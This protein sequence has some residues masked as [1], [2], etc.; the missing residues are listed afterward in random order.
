[1]SR[2]LD[3]YEKGM[4]SPI[5]P[6]LEFTARQ[7]QEPFR[8]LQ[9]GTHIGKVIV[10]MPEKAEE[11]PLESVRQDFLLR[12]DRAYLFVGGLG[13][14]GRSIAVWLT[15]HGAK[16]IVFFSRSAGKIEPDDLFLQELAAVGCSTVMVSGSVSNYEDVER[17][18]KAAPVPIAGV[19]QASMVLRVSETPSVVLIVV[20]VLIRAGHRLHRH[21]MG[22]MAGSRST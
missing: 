21:V 5:K 18:T 15:E 19:L 9:K 11:L 22:A 8:Y 16:H 13:G 14:L 20:Q 1:M 4:I 3:Y 17:A 6:T 7:I 12:P 10:T 2:A